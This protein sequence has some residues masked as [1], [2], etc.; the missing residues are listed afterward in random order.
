MT[1]PYSDRRWW[2]LPLPPRLDLPPP[3]TVI[4]LADILVVSFVAGDC[5]GLTIRFERLGAAGSVVVVVEL[6]FVDRVLIEES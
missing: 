4:D 1:E 3:P 5:N 6:S 2:S